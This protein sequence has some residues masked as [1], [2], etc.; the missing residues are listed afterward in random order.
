MIRVGRLCAASVVVSPCVRQSKSSSLL[1]S[2]TVIVSSVSISGRIKISHL[3]YEVK[4]NSIRITQ[5]RSS[6]EPESD[7]MCMECSKV[8]ELRW[9]KI[10]KF[11]LTSCGL[12]K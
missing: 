10:H 11:V 4:N 8:M 6:G 7:V 5:L 3:V 1:I 12:Y 9:I 2:R